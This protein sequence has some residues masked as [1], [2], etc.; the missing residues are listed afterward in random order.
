MDRWTV[1]EQ[2]RARIGGRVELAQTIRLA[3]IGL[4]AGVSAVAMV[5]GPVTLPLVDRSVPGFLVGGIGLLVTLVAY[6][7]VG[8]CAGCGARRSIGGTCG[9]SGSCER[10]G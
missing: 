1:I 8:W 5:D 7:Q 6:R 2:A 4:L 10:D 9:C 3:G